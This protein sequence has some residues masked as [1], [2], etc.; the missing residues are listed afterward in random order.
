MCGRWWYEARVEKGGVGLA[1]LH[2]RFVSAAIGKEQHGSVSRLLLTLRYPPSRRRCRSSG[3]TH[4][5]SSAYVGK[6]AA[7]SPQA[8]I[9]I[10]TLIKAV[11]SSHH[12]PRDLLR[13][14]GELNQ[15]CLAL[16]VH[17]HHLCQ[18]PP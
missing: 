10:S 2:F 17:L 15:R 8:I 12:F 4:T 7:N 11:G 13:A 1:E 18:P 6:R 5:I 16:A 3:K 14:V 9:H